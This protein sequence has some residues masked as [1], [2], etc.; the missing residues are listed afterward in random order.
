MYHRLC[1]QYNACS[2]SSLQSGE[3][4]LHIAVRYCHWD[5][6]DE[7]LRFVSKERSRYDATLLVNTQNGVSESGFN[8]NDFSTALVYERSIGLSLYLSYTEQ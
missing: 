3:N 1:H 6:A 4:P 7:L 8:K 5:V 2:C